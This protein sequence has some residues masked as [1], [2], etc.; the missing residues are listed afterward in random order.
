MRAK[1]DASV[2]IDLDP[3]DERSRP[4]K[5]EGLMTP[6][7][8][9]FVT[10]GSLIFLNGCASEDILQAQRGRMFGRT[11]AFAFYSG[12]TGFF[13]PV[14]G[15]GRITPAPTTRYTRSTAQR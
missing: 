14:L 1:H 9:L 13:G 8:R 5:E 12:K 4:K 11:G 2:P 10:L 3:R 15:P 7:K 6:S